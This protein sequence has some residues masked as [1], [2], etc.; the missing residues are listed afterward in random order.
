MEFVVQ[1]AHRLA[2]SS[3]LFSNVS[4]EQDPD[5]GVWMVLDRPTVNSTD[6]DTHTLLPWLDDY[7][8]SRGQP[9][10]SGDKHAVQS[11]PLNQS[12]VASLTDPDLVPLTIA[13]LQ[14]AIVQM[15]AEMHWLTKFYNKTL[16]YAR[17]RGQWYANDYLVPD[18]FDH[19]P[20]EMVAFALPSFDHERFPERNSLGVFSVRDNVR[21]EATMGLTRTAVVLALLTIASVAFN[22]HNHIHVILPSVTEKENTHTHT[23]THTHSTTTHLFFCAYCSLLFLFLPIYLILSYV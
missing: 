15:D 3:A 4:A 22:L 9:L 1:R 6:F 20:A 14:G 7:S 19:R 10:P 5:T 13:A 17:V 2:S 8:S 23:H 12:Y 18:L 16:L 11:P 21:Q